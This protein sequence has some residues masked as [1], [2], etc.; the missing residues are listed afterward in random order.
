MSRSAVDPLVLARLRETVQRDPGRMTMQVARE[1]GV[2]E[3]E[4]V[5]AL[6]DGR[7]VELDAK[8]WEGLLRALEGCGDVHVIVSNG[9]T[10][11]E[12]V[13]RFGGFSTT[14]PFFNV[15]SEGLDMHVRWQE[16][17]SVFAV[18]KP[19]HLNGVKTLS[20]QFYDRDGAAAFKV[21]LN[22]G[23]A[24]TPERAA[25]FERLRDEYRL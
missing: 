17:G 23:G 20:V 13:G 10:T 19:G 8:R 16:L 4:V 25:F 12:A 1:F 6:P 22:F 2:A 7:S 15:Q 11:I 21:F 18:E 14:G 24:A 3:A 9:A 5:R